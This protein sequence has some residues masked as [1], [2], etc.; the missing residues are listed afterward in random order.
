MVL[1]VMFYLRLIFWAILWRPTEAGSLRSI[2]FFFKILE[3][4]GEMLEFIW[5]IPEFFTT[6]LILGGLSGYN[7][8]IHYWKKNFL[9]VIVN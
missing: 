2:E 5:K 4:F 9:L 8:F 3:F 6:S 7:P 1:L